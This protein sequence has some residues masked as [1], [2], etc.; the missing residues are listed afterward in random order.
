MLL[1]LLILGEAGLS[2]MHESSRLWYPPETHH[3]GFMKPILFER[4]LQGWK[5]VEKECVPG[6]CYAGYADPPQGAPPSLWERS[7]WIWD[8]G[9]SYINAYPLFVLPSAVAIA[10]LPGSVY[11]PWIGLRV[12]MALLLLSAYLLGKTLRGPLTGLLSAVLCA[13]TPGLF[14][15]GLVYQDSVPLAAVG[16]ALAA[17]LLATRGFERP[18]ACWAVAM[19]TF[20]AFRVA[21]NVGEAALVAGVCIAPFCAAAL[22]G[23]TAPGDRSRRWDRFELTMV[24]AAVIAIRTVMLNAD[25]LRYVREGVE[26]G[27]Y[28]WAKDFAWLPIPELGY[29][30]E[31]GRDLLRPPMAIVLTLG[32]LLVLRR[33]SRDRLAVLGMHVVPLALLSFV[34]R[35]GLMYIV[36]A[37]PALAVAAAL[38]IATLSTRWRARVALIGVAAAVWT[39]GTAMFLPDGLRGELAYRLARQD[40]RSPEVEKFV[41][42]LRPINILDGMHVIPAVY[43]R[44]AEAQ[45]AVGIAEVARLHQREGQALRIALVSTSVHI[46]QATCWYIQVQAPNTTCFTPL[47]GGT[48][49]A[50][51]MEVDPRR[52]DLLA[53]VEDGEG[54]LSMPLDASTPLP[55]R[56]VEVISRDQPDWQDATR[57]FLERLHTVA[58]EAVPVPTGTVYV[59]KE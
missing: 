11:A 5:P 37:L 1:M 7:R 20:A 14:G 8:S 44:R 40:D 25:A 3:D 24:P 51:P 18:R 38:G 46:A 19:L 42:R 36:P 23:L 10:A 53:W 4:E 35:K 52:Y 43:A 17:A 31:L 41:D 30:E 16:T 48:V 58:W 6:N 59:R 32:A 28:G 50:S 15:L 55:D 39:R 21:E 49:R 56:L 33:P 47:W 2:W 54:P 13:G 12:W 45:A 9:P 29:I 22:E 26:T 27:P 34:N 57:L